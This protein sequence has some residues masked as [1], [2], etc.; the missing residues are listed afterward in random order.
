MDLKDIISNRGWFVISATQEE[1]GAHDDLANL[2][3]TLR[4][5]Q[6]LDAL[7]LSYVPCEGVY[8]GVAQGCSFLVLADEAVGRDLCAGYRQESILTPDGLIDA[9]GNLLARRTG[10]RFDEEALSSEFY[11]V[12]RNGLFW[13]ADLEFI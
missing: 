6:Q 13:S 4:L 1:L 11:S 2:A 10:D 8:R 12:F 9:D 3:A 5:S 7:D